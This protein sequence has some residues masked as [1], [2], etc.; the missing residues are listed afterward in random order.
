MIPLGVRPLLVV[1]FVLLRL[2]AAA[3]A[4]LY[5]HEA[6]AQSIEALTHDTKRVRLKLRE[7][8]SFRFTPGQY[9]FL[10]I[11]EAF[12]SSWN[13]RYGTAHGDVA[14]PYSFA[15]SSSKL[16]VFDWIV[17]LAAA[18]PGKNL[19][20]GIASTYVHEELK[21]GAVV[22][23][24]A[25]M[26]NLFLRKET[27]RPILI[28]AGGTG[29]AP[30]LSLLEYWFENQFDRGNEIYFFFGVRSR[31][32]LFLHDQFLAW[33]KERENFHYIP[34]LSHPAPDD[35]WKG[36]TG[37]INAVVDRHVPG[38]SDAD[39][40]I[41]GPPIMLKETVKVLTAKGVAAA[42]IHYDEIEVR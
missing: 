4:D 2:V 7:G 21:P 34:A 31:R 41:A 20:P 27:G 6:E 17:K 12:V 9:V 11:P 42:R 35:E 29:A 15:S 8:Q 32:D 13:A 33:S 18:P 3:P 1:V 19:P 38:P 36:E 24:S 37:Y 14:R 40:Y 26:G 23:I 16:P 25:P 5:K 28:I 22:R 10:K 39:A 30:F